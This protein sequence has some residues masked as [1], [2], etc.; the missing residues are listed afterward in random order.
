MVLGIACG[1][2]GLS[3]YLHLV[4]LSRMHTAPLHYYVFYVTSFLAEKGG[5]AHTLRV[6]KP[7]IQKSSVTHG[8]VHSKN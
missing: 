3:E 5:F 1:V 7:G 8:R 4:L 6:E 2:D